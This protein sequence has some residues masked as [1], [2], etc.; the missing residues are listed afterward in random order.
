MPR[1]L[2]SQELDPGLHG[3]PLLAQFLL[4]LA[5]YAAICGASSGPPLFPLPGT[6]CS[7]SWQSV[8]PMLPSMHGI[9]LGAF[10][11]VDHTPCALTE[12]S[13][14]LLV[15]DRTSDSTDSLSQALSFPIA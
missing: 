15:C 5:W 12:F 10:F 2:S 7:A 8:R 11:D 1:G 4:H 14:S 3:H 6:A 9:V 13:S